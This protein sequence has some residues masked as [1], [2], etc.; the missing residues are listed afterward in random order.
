MDRNVTNLF[1]KYSSTLG[2]FINTLNSFFKK[3]GLFLQLECNM[4][5]KLLVL[6]HLKNSPNQIFKNFIDILNFSK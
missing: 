5:K 4:D 3:K 1:K 2:S 6:P